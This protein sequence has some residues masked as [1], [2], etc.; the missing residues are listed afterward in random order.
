MNCE[1]CSSLFLIH[2]Q[3]MQQEHQCSEVLLVFA[4]MREPKYDPQL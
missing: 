4:L 1:D 3:D 2:F